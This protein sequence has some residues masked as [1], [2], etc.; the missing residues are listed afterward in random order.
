MRPR[1]CRGSSMSPAAITALSNTC[2]APHAPMYVWC[3]AKRQLRESNAT[4]GGRRPGSSA[5]LLRDFLCERR[6]GG[7]QRIEPDDDRVLEV[8][9]QFLPLDSHLLLLPLGGR[10]HQPKEDTAINNSLRAAAS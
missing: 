10:K 5:R 4:E 8:D 7:A 1:I 9:A 2:H 6:V 3:T